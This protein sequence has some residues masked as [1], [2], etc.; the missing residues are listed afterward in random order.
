MAGTITRTPDLLDRLTKEVTPQGTVSY[1][2][3]NADRRET[4]TVAGQTA[5]SYTFD[6][7]NRL[8][9]ISQCGTGTVG[10]TYDN[11]DRR[12]LLTLPDGAT[13]AYVYDNGGLGDSHVTSMTYKDGTTTIGNSDLHV[14]PRRAPEHGRR[15]LAAVTIPD[16]LRVYQH[17]Q[18]R[19]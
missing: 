6:N 1:T 19:Q 18:R 10:F 2:Y 12:T 3:D 13:Q 4:M 8:T 14:R 11:A 15:S 16:R 17:L 7:A 5:V 9:Q